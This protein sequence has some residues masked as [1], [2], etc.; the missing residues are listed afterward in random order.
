MCLEDKEQDRL[1]NLICCVKNIARESPSI[2]IQK[3]LK[4]KPTKKLKKKA[5]KG[6][7]TIVRI[8][9]ET[10]HPKASKT[11]IF[12][13]AKESL[14]ELQSVLNDQT[15]PLS[16]TLKSIVEQYQNCETKLIKRALLGETS[17]LKTG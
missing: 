1:D 12:E 14:T 11:E 15:N 7:A 16:E 2:P 13:L 4:S 8:V 5:I 17:E 9:C 3:P 6:A 10:L